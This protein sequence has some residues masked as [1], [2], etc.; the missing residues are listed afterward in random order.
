MAWR[1]MAVATARRTL[2]S[3]SAALSPFIVM[4]RKSGPAACRT[5]A[6]GLL[7]ARA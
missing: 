4:C 5:T 6:P 3:E 7:L 1:L 2:T